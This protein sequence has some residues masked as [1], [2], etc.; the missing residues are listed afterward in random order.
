MLKS[1]SALN[2]LLQPRP[3]I[4]YSEKDCKEKLYFIEP[5]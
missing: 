2:G 1:K 3:Y 4:S 5:T